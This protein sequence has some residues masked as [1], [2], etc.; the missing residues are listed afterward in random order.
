MKEIYFIKQ[1]EIKKIN[2]SKIN[3]FNKALILAAICRVNTLSI[4]KRA[5]SGH[6]G[7]SFSAMDLFI[8]LKYFEFP[9][10]K[11]I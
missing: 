5:G 4:I 10:K 9:S 11:K 8:W 2:N 6:I 1:D 3:K 7:T